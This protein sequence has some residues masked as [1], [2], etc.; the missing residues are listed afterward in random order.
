MMAHIEEK[1]LI[2]MRTDLSGK[3]TVSL[4]HLGWTTA[5]SWP[6]PAKPPPAGRT[7]VRAAERARLL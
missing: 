5:P 4:P 2:V 3:R 6:D 1:G 7:V